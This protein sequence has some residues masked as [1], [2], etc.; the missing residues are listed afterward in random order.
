MHT[1]QNVLSF[2]ERLKLS[3]YERD[4][5]L[6]VVAHRDVATS[7]NKLKPYKDLVIDNHTKSK[8][9]DLKD[10]VCE[11]LKFRGDLESCQEIREWEVPKFPVNG[12]DL[13]AS[14][15]PPGKFF[16][17]VM[18]QL[19]EHWKDSN[20]QLDREGILEKLPEIVKNLDLSAAAHKNKKQR[21]NSK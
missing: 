11:T 2:H 15:C 1:E 4:L 18:K 9:R 20:F 8:P 13:K 14:G 16:A 21:K 3:G 6:F 17:I 10:F 5:G 19:K 7:D 12:H